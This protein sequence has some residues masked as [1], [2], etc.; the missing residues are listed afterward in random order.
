MDFPVRLAVVL[1]V[2]LTTWPTTGFGFARSY[3]RPNPKPDRTTMPV[4]GA[5]TEPARRP[6]P[7]PGPIAQPA[8]PSEPVPGP[9][10]RPTPTQPDP[11]TIAQP[12][13]TDPPVPYPNAP[14]VVTRP[15][16]IPTPDE[17][18]DAPTDNETNPSTFTTNNETTPA[19][20]PGEEPGPVVE[21]FNNSSPTGASCPNPSDPFEQHD[22][23]FA[24]APTGRPVL[25][26]YWA[27]RS[28]YAAHKA[29]MRNLFDWAAHS[30][31]SET[32]INSVCDGLV[33]KGVRNVTNG[34][35]D[36]MVITPRMLLWFDRTSAYPMTAGVSAI[37]DGGGGRLRGIWLLHL[38][39]TGNLNFEFPA[40]HNRG[41]NEFLPGAL[42]PYPA[43]PD[44]LMHGGGFSTFVTLGVEYTG[45]TGNSENDSSSTMTI[46]APQA[47]IEPG[48]PADHFMIWLSNQNPIAKWR[49]QPMC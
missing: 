40:N 2:I 24:L 26:I 39:A 4:P 31:C 32:P 23:I 13:P 8:P 36:V 46:H 30:I 27:P 44:S 35:E 1:G 37:P 45:H 22:E 12:A 20:P 7:F 43:A 14:L 29:R 25:G 41:V 34:Y 9:I 17:N 47:M 18:S 10:A 11:G 21:R 38:D 5:S 19:N 28:F 15:A 33:N 16:P 6:L 42:F 49:R 3:R 48:A